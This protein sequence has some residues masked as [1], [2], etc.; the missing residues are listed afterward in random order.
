MIEFNSLFKILRGNKVFSNF[1]SLSVLQGVNYILPI[2]TMPYLVRVL[3]VERFGLLSFITAFTVYFQIIIDYGFNLSATRIAA[4]STNDAEKL[5]DIFNAVSFTK[6]LLS[7]IC[8]L[9]LIGCLCVSKI[10]MDNWVLCMLSFGAIF[11]QS[12]LPVWF[13]LGIERMKFIT[14]F[15]VLSKTLF[16]ISIFVFVQQES[17]YLLVPISSAIGGLLALIFASWV[18][19]KKFNVRL[20]FPK[21]EL[22]VNQLTDG[23]YVFIS[24]LATSLYTV[25][26]MVILGFLTNSVLVGYY[27]IADRLISAIKSINGPI[28][29]SLYPYVS[30]NSAE[31]K[32]AT[33]RFLKKTVILLGSFMFMVS[34][35]IIIFA[36]PFVLIIFGEEALNSV[37]IIRVLAFVPMLVSFDTVFGTLTLI[38]FNRAKLFTGI[39]LSAGILNVIV[40]TI[41]I[42]IYQHTGAAISVLLVELFICVRLI[43]S[44]QTSDLKIFKRKILV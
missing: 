30:R 6:I 13:F 24:N 7:V 17:D 5:N 18:L 2:V 28:S 23:W 11:L 32:E 9:V 8:L 21:K 35:I 20:K 33:L 3:G 10:L 29:Q 1:L 37:L 22:I 15:S 41:L 44:V 4:L 27:S 42:S 12:T 25:T 14:Y 43:V 16:T 26:T 31:S 40:S 19:L 36:Q 38:A 39:I 34:L